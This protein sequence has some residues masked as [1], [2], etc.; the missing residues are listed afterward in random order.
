MIYWFRYKTVDSLILRVD[1][2]F[3]SVFRPTEHVQY[4]EQMHQKLETSQIR[5]CLCGLKAFLSQR[6][7]SVYTRKNSFK[8]KL[9]LLKLVQCQFG[10]FQVLFSL[11]F[12]L[13]A[14]LYEPC[15][16]IICFLMCD[17]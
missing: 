15:Y 7:A 12:V 5:N 4:A 10:E 6:M 8:F 14:F 16:E 9:K 1:L 2:L 17:W 3:L 13:C 11:I